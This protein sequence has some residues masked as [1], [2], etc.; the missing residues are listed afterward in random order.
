VARIVFA[1]DHEE[2]HCFPTFKLARQLAGRGHIVTYLGLPDTGSLVRR[3]GFSFV[4]ML[5][6]F[7]PEGTVAQLRRDLEGRSASATNGQTPGFEE[8]EDRYLGALALGEGLDG[9]VAEIQPVCS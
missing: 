9:P 2:G 1:L 4:P 8:L 6:R 3:Q 5:E 7:F